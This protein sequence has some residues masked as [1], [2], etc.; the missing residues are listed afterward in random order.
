[1]LD[2]RL[3]QTAVIG[4][5]NSDHPVILPMDAWELD[6]WRKAHPGY[7]YWCGLQLGG[8]GGELS[9]RRYTTKVCHFAHHSTAPVC[10]RK[11]NGE[12][13]ADHLFIKRGVQRLLGKRQVKGRVET[14]DL[15]TGPG[16][17]VDVYL[18][19]SRRRLRFQLGAV[20]YRAWRRADDELAADA[21]GMDWIFSSEGPITQQFVG[22]H[23]YCLRVRCETVGGERRVHIGAEARDRTVS[24]TPLEECAVTSSGIATPETEKI[25]LIRPRPTVL[26]LQGGLVFALDP[27]A[28][29][30]AGSPFTAEDRHL[31]VADVKPVDSPIVRALVSLPGDTKVPPAEHVY[32]VADGARLLIAEGTAGWAVEANRYVRLN[33]HE[34][35]RTG[36]WVPP[37]IPESPFV[38]EPVRR[39]AQAAPP[40]TT[41]A[42]T[43][44]RTAVTE[45]PPVSGTPVAS[46]PMTRA[47]LVTALRDALS[48]HARLHTTTTWET[49][50]RTVNPELARYSHTD[51]RYLLVELDSPLRDHAP[52]LSALIREG[53]APLPYLSNILSQ[54]GVAYAGTPSRIKRWAVVET[55][56][57]FAAYGTPPR[58]MPPRF[59]LRPEQPLVRQFVRK[60]GG[61]GLTPEVKVRRPADRQV[62]VARPMG[63]TVADTSMV[64]RLRSLLQEL[65]G[66]L[67]LVDKP[68]RKRAREVISET[69][70]WLAHHD[71]ALLSAAQRAK[72]ADRS[73]G[74]HVRLVEDELKAVNGVLKA[75]NRRTDKEAKRL[76]RMEAAQSK[77]RL[78][79]SGEPSRSSTPAEDPV[80]R[81]RSQLIG[82]AAQGGNVALGDLNTS[83]SGLGPRHWLVT[84]DRRA[85]ADSF[86]LLSAL[87][88]DAH[89]G[90]VV[91]FRDVL[92]AAGLAVPRT[93]E[94]LLA[95]WRREQERAHAA[96]AR[97]P[98]PLPPRLVPRASVPKDETGR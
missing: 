65:T 64:K 88:V 52:V 22:R 49:L 94:A 58:T 2:H 20:D 42:V 7:S 50:A 11:N 80:D 12:S 61:A 72:V 85:G 5:K 87:V 82:V 6:R 32:R 55:E 89:G 16:D 83:E 53:D 46:A 28:D 36:L 86:P 70:T 38:P 31:L 57:A 93:E 24:W 27:E 69:Q 17:V 98:R 78:A 67:S 62:N 35:Q 95:I 15:G 97:P 68:T 9:D 21:D 8:C 13:S 45:P 39:A 26:P 56:R 1:M 51:R 84:L 23:G 44:T 79:R 96:H 19:D 59:S 43:A 75:A 91:F 18:P 77:A 41:Q 60:S 14:R 54:L 66:L 40:P 63:R 48:H 74:Y 76:A 33:A 4:H 92:G 34:A 29:V 10:H 30:P 25:R 3:V 73:S 47:E 37:S 90:P 71:G 81:L